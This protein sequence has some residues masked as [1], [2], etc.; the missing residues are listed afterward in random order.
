M[1]DVRSFDV[2]RS[3]LGVHSPRIYISSGEAS[4]DLHGAGVVRALRRRFPSAVID[5]TGGPH[6]ASAGASL[7][8]SS[9]TCEAMGIVEVVRTLPR[10]WSILTDLSG[11]FRAGAY[12]LV[13]LIDYPGF[14]VRLARAAARAGIP[15][16]YYIAPQLWAWGSGR[17]SRL[18]RS[19]RELAVILPF[20]ED[21]FRRLDIPATFVGHPLLDRP[22]PPAR[23]DARARQGIPATAP[24]VAL[25]PGSRPQ[26][27]ERMWPR[28]RDAAKQ[29]R[30][31]HPE[32]GVVVAGTRRFSYPGAEDFAVVWDAPGEV[33]AAAD[34]VL[35]KSGTATLEAALADVPMV[36]SYR[37]NPITFGIARHL[38]CTPHISLVNLVAG[39]AVVPEL[40]QEAATSHA[41]A[42]SLRPL[43]DRNSAASRRQREAFG[44]VRAK[45]GRPGAGERVAEIASRLVA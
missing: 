45:L 32:L 14:H 33:L 34:A 8:H 43:L 15:V 25:F 27:H 18:R 35:C 6:M 39:R 26:E 3:M 5:A 20:E 24:V 19:I 10:H 23:A 38:V 36:V 2:R 9:A 21:F 12:D 7:R 37:L 42:D 41:L 13:V 40:L 31:D 44:E 16:L 22:A 4:G 17:S 30:G 28:F 11:A 1:V 29:L